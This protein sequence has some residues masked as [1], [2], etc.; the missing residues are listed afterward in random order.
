MMNG[1][2]ANRG[3]LKKTRPRGSKTF[4]PE[5]KREVDVGFGSV[6]VEW[7]DRQDWLSNGLPAGQT[8]E[9]YLAETKG[10]KEAA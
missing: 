9:E 2:R 10:E 4:W 5:M 1:Y 6:F 7:H 3:L 8:Y